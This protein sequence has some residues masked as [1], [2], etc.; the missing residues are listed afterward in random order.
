MRTRFCATI[1]SPA[2]S[3]MALTAP[4]RLRAV[5][6]GLMIEKVRSTAMALFQLSLQLPVV[7]SNRENFTCRFNCG[8]HRNP[9]DGGAYSR[10]AVGR[11]G[12]VACGLSRRMKLLDPLSAWFQPRPLALLSAHQPGT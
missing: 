10:L 9:R 3:I 12:V 6:S 4:V 11:Q 2:C 5:A 7:A 8:S 1:R